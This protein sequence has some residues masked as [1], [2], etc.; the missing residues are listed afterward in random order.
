[1]ALSNDQT[2]L[3]LKLKFYIYIYIFEGPATTAKSLKDTMGYH[4]PWALLWQSEMALN[5]CLRCL[6]PCPLRPPQ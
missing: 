4:T 3:V 5:L 6:S 2:V 1:M